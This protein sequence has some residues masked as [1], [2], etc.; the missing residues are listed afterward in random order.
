[1]GGQRIGRREQHPGKSL[2]DAGVKELKKGEKGGKQEK[3]EQKRQAASQRVFL[4]SFP[5]R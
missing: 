3:E 2:E 1:M 4:L 5:M